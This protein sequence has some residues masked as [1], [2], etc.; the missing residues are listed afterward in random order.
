MAEL[1]T[2]EGTGASDGH[3]AGS[4]LE[5]YLTE[6]KSIRSI[7]GGVAETSYYPALSNLFNSV[8]KSLKP[9][10]QCVMNLKNAGAGMP[11]GGL[12]TPE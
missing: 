3:Q 12:F 4:I 8:G 6:L 2:D 1:D 7:G 5:N 11:D 9:K 10:V